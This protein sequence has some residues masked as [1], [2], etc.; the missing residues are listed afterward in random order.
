[1]VIMSFQS[2]INITAILGGLGSFIALFIALIALAKSSQSEKG[3]NLLEINNILLSDK[4]YNVYKRIRNGK[5][6]NDIW[7]DVDEY[8][9]LFEIC[10]VLIKQNVLDF[11]VFKKQF[12]LK[13]LGIL[14]N[15]GIVFHKIIKEY[16]YWTNLYLLI[17]MLDKDMKILSLSKYLKKIERKYSIKYLDI[18][19]LSEITDQLSEEERIELKQYIELLVKESIN[20]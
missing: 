4:Y 13:V 18:N 15:N 6:I 7:A 17:D 10:Y 16:K 12:G 9:G 20:I 19:S 8:L 5:A 1:M 14:N 2:M 3:K 11:K